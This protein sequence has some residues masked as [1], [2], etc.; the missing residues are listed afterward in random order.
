MTGQPHLQSDSTKQL[1]LR[2]SLAYAAP[3]I[4]VA[5]LSGPIAL[6]QGIYA[7]YF[8]LSLGTIAAVVLI[9]RLFDAFTDPLIGFLSDRFHR[10]SGSRKSFILAGGILFVIS[11]YFLYV[12]VGFGTSDTQVKVSGAYFLISFLG[13]Y[14]AYTLFEI[15]HLAWGSEIGTSSEDKNKIYSLRALAVSIG[16]MLFFAVPLLPFFGSS[17]FTPETLSWSVVLAGILMVPCLYICVKSV[18]NGNA[19]SPNPRRHKP[20]KRERLKNI[21]RLIVGNKPFLIFIAAF[22]SA[23]AGVGMWFGMMFLFVDVYLGLGHQLSL[24]FMLSYGFSILIVKLWYETAA[25]YGKKYTWGLGMFLVMLGVLGTG[26][27]TPDKTS[28]LALL[29]CMLLIKGGVMATAIL[30]PS[31]LADIIDYG[32]WK[33][34]GGFAA[35]YFSLYTLISKANVAIGGALGLA[36]AG[37]FGFDPVITNSPQSD[38]AITGLLISVA[39][40]PTLLIMISIRF[41]LCVPIDARRHSIIHRRLDARRQVNP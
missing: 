38:Q 15:T 41:I 24:I 18:P 29:V 21:M 10:H 8:G 22:V 1:N 2:T 12:P 26:F 34:G 7:K 36:I 6:V 31:L 39:W 23:G 28:W 4:A 33:F 40:L 30:A 17:D 14:L 16:L 9:A 20:S 27:L 5:F 37:I 32:S 11:S 3:S 35:T 13:F 25:K 19:I